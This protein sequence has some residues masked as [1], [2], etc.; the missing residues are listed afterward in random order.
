[1]S[2]K[3]WRVS[4]QH[5]RLLTFVKMLP[6]FSE[7]RY[8]HETNNPA[9]FVRKLPT[10]AN[11]GPAHILSSQLSPILQ[12]SSLPDRDLKR[13]NTPCD[14]RSNLESPVW[15]MFCQLLFPTTWSPFHWNCE[16]EHM[17]VYLNNLSGF[18]FIYCRISLEFAMA[19]SAAIHCNLC[20]HWSVINVRLGRCIWL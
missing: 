20:C 13:G 7:L 15:G 2:D 16:K 1:M 10:I 6:L 4:C 11:H 19:S 8:F 14:A 17:S 3:N 5:K 9:E 12:W 18:V